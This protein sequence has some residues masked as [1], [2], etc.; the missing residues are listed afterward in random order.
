MRKLAHF[1]RACWSAGATYDMRE[2]DK[3]EKVGTHATAP[4][5]WFFFYNFHCKTRFS[6]S[7]I[8][9]IPQARKTQKLEIIRH[10]NKILMNAT[11]FLVLVDALLKQWSKGFVLPEQ[12]GHIDSPECSFQENCGSEQ[13]SCHIYEKNMV[14]YAVSEAKLLFF[15]L[16]NNTSDCLK[17]DQ[18]V[19]RRKN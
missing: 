19:A 3:T 7:G 14:F 10:Q 8:A 13:L 4:A 15:N 16:E 6:Q 2:E 18:S 12:I 17:N 9:I 1:A 11:N 5:L